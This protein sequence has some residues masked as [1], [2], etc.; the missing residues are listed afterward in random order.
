MILTRRGPTEVTLAEFNGLIE[1]INDFARTHTVPFE[2]RWSLHE[3]SLALEA[4]K[5]WPEP[6]ASPRTDRAGPDE[7]PDPRH[8]VEPGKEPT[9]KVAVSGRDRDKQIAAA[10]KAGHDFK[11]SE[12]IA[13]LADFE[14]EAKTALDHATVR[15]V[16]SSF[17]DSHGF[18]KE[19][20]SAAAASELKSRWVEI[21]SKT[22]STKDLI[23]ALKGGAPAAAADKTLTSKTLVVTIYRAP[24]G[25][26]LEAK[27]SEESGS[28]R[29]AHVEPIYFRRSGFD[30][31]GKRFARDRG[32][33]SMA[34]AAGAHVE[35]GI[36][37]TETPRSDTKRNVGRREWYARKR[38]A[39][40]AGGSGGTT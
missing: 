20:L 24:N 16:L 32:D 22:I 38:E 13:L 26:A 9:G 4:G 34:G 18:H 12:L 30:V 19:K 1:S 39:E 28:G 10:E 25:Y 31:Y 8:I 11:S 33:V 37:P 36:K 6:D 15:G 29:V 40:R 17:L 35:P 3:A 7:P 21:A 23:R 5:K 14:R 2:V 27:Q